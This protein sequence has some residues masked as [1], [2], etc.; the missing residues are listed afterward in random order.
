[1][2]LLSALSKLT[3]KTAS[4]LN[5]NVELRL[6][7][8]AISDPSQSYE[9]ASKILS[10][11]KQLYAQEPAATPA[12]GGRPGVTDRMSATPRGTTPDGGAGNVVDFR[13]LK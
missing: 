5:S 12:P 1:M 4:Q 7:L 11:L 3:G 6:N 9:A 8:D 13:S 10:N 2:S